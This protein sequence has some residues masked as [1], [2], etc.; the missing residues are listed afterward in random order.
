MTV[1]NIKEARAKLEAQSTASA[2]GLAPEALFDFDME[3]ILR[4]TGESGAANGSSSDPVVLQ[5]ESERA[6]RAL[7]AEFGFPRLPLTVAEFHTFV[8]YC[9]MLDTSSGFSM[10]PAG[11]DGRSAWQAVSVPK[12]CGFFPQHAEAIRLYAAG[13]KGEL[14]ALHTQNKT[15]EQLAKK[16]GEF[17]NEPPEDAS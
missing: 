13:K 8:E 10:L 3:G 4:V 12:Y 11:G 16:Y 17:D 6:M 5:G 2:E 1:T 14:L 15:L 7:M 9:Q